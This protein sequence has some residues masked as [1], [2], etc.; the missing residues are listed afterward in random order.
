MNA[1][2]GTVVAYRFLSPYEKKKFKLKN[3]DLQHYIM[4]LL[5]NLCN[6]QY[7]MQME[8]HFF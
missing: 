5:Q 6:I 2:L 7:I 3:I 4:M 8:I 1:H